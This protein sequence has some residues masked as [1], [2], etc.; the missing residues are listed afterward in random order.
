MPSTP[1]PLRWLHAFESALGWLLRYPLLP[2][3]ILLFFLVAWGRL[4]YDLGAE[5]LFWSEHAGEQILNGVAC[6]LLFGEVLLVR[7]LL[8]PNRRRFSF[9][10]SLFPV[11]DADVRRLGAYLL[12]LWIPSLLVLWGG[13]LFFHDVWTGDVRVWALPI[14]LVLAVGASVG[15]IGAASRFDFLTRLIRRGLPSDT[16]ALSLHGVALLTT[17]L[18]VLALFLLYVLHFSGSVFSPILVLCVLLILADAV[19]GFLAFWAPGSQFLALVLVVGFALLANNRSDHA[20]KLTFPNLEDQY[21]NPLRIDEELVGEEGGKHKRLDHYY[22]LLRK[23]AD[24]EETKPDLIAS[25]GPVRAMAE[26]WRQEH[27][28]GSKPR[29]VLIATSGGGIR[30]AV[31]TAVVLD[32]LEREIGPPFRDHIRLFTGASGGMVGAALYVADFENAPADRSPINPD[33]GLRGLSEELARDSF[34][35]PY[36]RCCC[37]TCQPYGDRA[38]S[39]GTG[40]ANSS[41]RGPRTPSERTDVRRSKS[42]STS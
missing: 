23:Q 14:G 6:G 17:L 12:R 24:G 9:R 18:S 25:E 20:Y 32:G 8:D 29:L 33:T 7:Y 39:T 38:S 19:Y 4:G 10:F 36:R 37:K 3:Q 21:A 11:A 28:D 26:R 30:A 40:D 5:D 27:N 13:K 15:V 16:E 2:L 41:K 1:S 22:E 31:W 34:A 42:R 35:A